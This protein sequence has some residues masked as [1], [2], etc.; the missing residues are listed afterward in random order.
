MAFFARCLLLSS[1]CSATAIAQQCDINFNYGVVIDPSHVRIL[2][3]GQTYVQIN[4]K[5]Q[6]FVNGREIELSD[7]QQVELKQYTAGIRK[8]VPAMVSIAVEGVELGLKTVNK[9]I[10]TLTGENSESHQKFQEK[11]DEMQWRLRTRFNHS[12]QSYYIAPQDFDDFD[13]VFAGEFDKEIETII[14][15][16]VGTILSAVGEAMTNHDAESSEQRMETFDQRIKTMGSDIKLG[17]SKRASAL[18]SKAEKICT[19]LKALDAIE[20]QLQQSIPALAKFN[21]IETN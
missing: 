11:F 3:R 16:S 13:E 20:N 12:D 5:S 14:T 17:V 1:L 7:T 2:D 10:S 9:V 6:L 4:G 8:Q 18:E 19:S 21:L 15:T